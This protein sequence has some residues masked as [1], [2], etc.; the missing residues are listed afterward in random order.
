MGPL[1]YVLGLMT[2]AILT[3]VAVVVWRDQRQ[4]NLSK[5]V[6]D[7]TRM[8]DI[9]REVSGM[10]DEVV[11]LLDGGKKRT[12]MI[13]QLEGQIKTLKNSLGQLE[14]R[15]ATGNERREQTRDKD[16]NQRPHQEKPHHEKTQPDRLHQDKPQREKPHQNRSNSPTEPRD[17]KTREHPFGKKEP[18]Q[19][20]I[21]QRQNMPAMAGM[22][23][24]QGP[25]PEIEIPSSGEVVLVPS[26]QEK[27]LS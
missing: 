17:I 19:P 7:L 10:R 12:E 18:D 1:I 14:Q 6:K 11:R 13:A 4:L 23:N 8:E 5:V 24:A 9:V 2:V 22:M 21:D 25:K 27:N 16:K 3:L 15:A 26:L 20:G